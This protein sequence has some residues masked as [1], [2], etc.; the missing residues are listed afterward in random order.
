MQIPIFILILISVTSFIYFVLILVYRY[1]NISLLKGDRVVSATENIKNFLNYLKGYILNIN[2]KFTGFKRYENI[3]L[4]IARLNLKKAIY[5]ENFLIYEE[6]S[7]LI[8]FLISYILFENILFAF[9]SAIAGFFVPEM[10]LKAK[11]KQKDDSILKELPN[12]ID[13]ISANIEGGL[14]I[15]KAISNYAEKNKNDFSEELKLVINN[16]N[17]GRSFSEALHDMN[18]KLNLNEITGFVNVFI[19]A[20]KF[21]GNVKEIIRAQADEIRAKRFQILKKKAHEAPVK[22]LIPLIIFIFPVIFIVLFGP[23][24]IRLMSGM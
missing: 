19:Q 23:V 22:L 12:A 6:A 8:S 20:D 24:I 14:S 15:I 10:I 16:I 4:L 17:I 1:K 7:F 2:K 18:N 11:V 5:I 3:K 13:I 21:G 9:I